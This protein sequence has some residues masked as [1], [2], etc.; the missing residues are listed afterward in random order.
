M[1]SLYLFAYDSLLRV[2]R[3]LYALADQC[4]AGFRLSVH[5]TP[6]CDSLGLYLTLLSDGTTLHFTTAVLFYRNSLHFCKLPIHAPKYPFYPW[7]HRR[8][9]DRASFIFQCRELRPGT[10]SPTISCS[11]DS[12]R[13]DKGPLIASLTPFYCPG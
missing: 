7:D 2:M 11:E 6:D 3:R 4:T 10:V 9:S 5:P 1:A 13:G 12:G 8:S